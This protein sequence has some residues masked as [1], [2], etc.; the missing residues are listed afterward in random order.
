[1]I[2]IGVRSSDN[3]HW[4]VPVR[5]VRQFAKEAKLEWLVDPKLP[6]PTEKDLEAIPL[7]LNQAVVSG[8]KSQQ[9]GPGE[10]LFQQPAKDVKEGFLMLVR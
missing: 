7:E 1:M 6:R 2:T 3:F 4:I 10:I 5:T 8:G 9:S